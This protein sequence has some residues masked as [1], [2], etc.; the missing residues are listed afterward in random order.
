MQ[1]IAKQILHLIE[2]RDHG[3]SESVYFS[4][5]EN[6]EERLTFFFALSD[7]FCRA[8]SQCAIHHP[9][10]QKL[11]QPSGV[12]TVEAINHFAGRFKLELSKI[13]RQMYHLLNAQSTAN[14]RAQS[15]SDEPLQETVT[16]SN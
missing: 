7:R 12:L 1:R 11:W 8:P 5:E 16:T 10:A 3:Q 2:Q 9:W 4:S 6:A 13:K 14:W 15:F